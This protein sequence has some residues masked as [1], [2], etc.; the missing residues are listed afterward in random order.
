LFLFFYGLIPALQEVESDF[1]NYYTSS[2]LLIEGRDVSRIYDDDWFNSR[3]KEFGIDQQGKF[4]P[5][6][7]VSA[8][9]MIPLAWLEPLTAK[10]IW[11][12]VNFGFLLLILILLNRITG[13]KYIL[14]GILILLGGMGLVNNFRFGQYYLVI[15][16]LI[17]LS[18]YL[19]QKGQSVLA[20]IL[21]GFAASVKYYPIIFLV[22][23]TLRR[24]YKTVVS[25][26]ITILIITALEILVFGW[27]VFSD[28]IVD[29]LI[30]HLGG[31]LSSQSVYSTAFQS[32][33][34]LLNRMFIPDTMENP[35]PVFDGTAGYLILKICIHTLVIG[36]TIFT[37]IRLNRY[38][39]SRALELQMA[40]CGIMIMVL[41]PASA[42]YHFILLL[43][44]VILL[45]QNDSLKLSPILSW[46]IILCYASIGFLQLVV[47]MNVEYNGLGILLAYPR[48]WI[49]TFLF[50][51]SVLF[52]YRLPLLQP[53]P[54]SLQ[55]G[56]SSVARRGGY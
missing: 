27:A 36:T 7:P 54:A 5:F 12:I 41:L 10:R 31:N 13:W 29:V 33:N 43:F 1:P 32:W 28:Y 11:T 20:G 47:P 8:F 34:S 38:Q 4:S 16:F 44:P 9:L 2:R 21:L 42:T 19:W 25:A 3:I 51:I 15:L 53:L 56:V 48:L 18:Y 45:L 24:E 40:I 50:F 35:S 6:P 55:G 30:P 14:L 22:P 37:I 49:I 52:V 17:I 46:M 23:F 39:P 26:L